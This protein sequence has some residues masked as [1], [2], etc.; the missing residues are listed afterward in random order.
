MGTLGRLAAILEH[1][2]SLPYFTVNA[3]TQVKRRSSIESR[4]V[5]KFPGFFGSQSCKKGREIR[6][7][8][9]QTC[10]TKQR[11]EKRLKHKVSGYKS[12]S[13]RRSIAG[14]RP[15]LRSLHSFQL[16]SELFQAQ[17]TYWRERNVRTCISFSVTKA[18]VAGGVCEG[19]PF[20]ISKY[21]AVSAARAPTDM[22]KSSNSKNLHILCENRL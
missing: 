4:T 9:K 18:V 5:S 8:L 14:C 16:S 20:A 10:K 13:K 3:W 19:K 17:E 1:T 7:Q 2:D 12:Q 11:K 15:L 22:K 6:K 21:F